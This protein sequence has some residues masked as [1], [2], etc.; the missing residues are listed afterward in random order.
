MTWENFERLGI[1]GGPTIKLL[2]IIK[3]FNS[4]QIEMS[5][6]LTQPVAQPQLPLNNVD[7]TIQVEPNQQ[8]NSNTQPPLENNVNDDSN[9]SNGS[10]NPSTTDQARDYSPMYPVRAWVSS[11][12]LKKYPNKNFVKTCDIGVMDLDDRN[13][14]IRHIVKSFIKFEND[15]GRDGYYPE[16]YSKTQLALDTIHNF[17]KMR[18]GSGLGHEYLYD[19]KSCTGLIQERLKTSR[20]A[21]DPKRKK[22][23][24]KPR[25]ST[26][27]QSSEP[28]P[29]TSTSDEADLLHPSAE[30]YAMFNLKV[31]KLQQLDPEKDEKTIFD[32][33]DETRA[34]RQREIKPPVERSVEPPADD[35]A[36]SSL[37]HIKIF[38]RYPR[39]LDFDGKL[40]SREY[41]ALYSDCSQFEENFQFYTPKIIQYCKT[42]NPSKLEEVSALVK[43]GKVLFTSL[44]DK[45]A[46]F[47]IYLH[48]D[49]LKAIILLSELVQLCT[50]AG[51]IDSDF[52][53]VINAG[54]Q[55][56]N[57][58]PFMKCNLN[59]GL[60]ANYRLT[61]DGVDI[62]VG[63]IT[64][65]AIELLLKA[66]YAF[67]IQFCTELQYFYN[68]ISSYFMLIDQPKG[69]NRSLH[70]SI[71]NTPV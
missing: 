20:K 58:Q 68:F 55:R 39:F 33:M 48:A 8:E 36:E 4:S 28:T 62:L 46:H 23:A 32:L 40:I 35:L 11:I 3:Q 42:V 5:N 44:Y 57:K 60:G 69:N 26:R 16:A 27:A 21:L 67:N 14:V 2:D 50:P 66:H 37:C 59:E 52:T 17:P 6:L 29:D 30:E 13:I 10:N 53:S 24:S 63:Q 22:R 9:K 54:T 47:T 45:A 31:E 43:E 38:D 25:S 56:P 7:Q 61:I 19:P 18:E 1:K 70:L 64:R 12:K 71:M 41:N 15:Q 51:R 49:D 65:K 34:L